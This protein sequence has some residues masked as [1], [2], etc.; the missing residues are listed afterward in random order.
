MIDLPPTEHWPADVL[1]RAFTEKQLCEAIAYLELVRTS[2]MIPGPEMFNLGISPLEYSIE[3]IVAVQR[4]LALAV[5][6]R[7]LIMS[8]VQ[9]SS[10]K[11]RMRMIGSVAA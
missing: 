3:E 6:K 11:R 4:R 5:Q 2:E 10:H 9:T 8:S 7:R 1:A